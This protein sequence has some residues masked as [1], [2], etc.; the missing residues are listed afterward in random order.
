[1]DRQ[2]DL[3]IWAQRPGGSRAKFGCRLFAS[4]ALDKLDTVKQYL[5]EGADPNHYDEQ[6]NMSFGPTPI[7]HA[8]SPS[9]VRLLVA[10]GADVNFQG[11]NGWTPLLT[12]ASNCRI[13]LVQALLEAGADPLM[14]TDD[15]GDVPTVFE[16]LMFDD[17]G[18]EGAGYL[19]IKNL[20]DDYAFRRRMMLA[21]DI[22][23]RDDDGESES[24]SS[25]L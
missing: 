24:G 13:T 9:M 5:D 1:M 2:E 18:D 21:A 19:G 11:H 15:G 22:A 10:A 25:F 4:A 7:F 14:E 23:S 20:I 16:E 8:Q 12:A 17:F 3:P 6:G